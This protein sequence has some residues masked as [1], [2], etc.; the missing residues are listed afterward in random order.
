MSKDKLQKEKEGRGECFKIKRVERRNI[1]S[2]MAFRRLCASSGKCIRS[3]RAF[4][5]TP[6]AVSSF[7]KAKGM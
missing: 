3:E 6:C 2:A 5:K 4:K 1:A 7:E